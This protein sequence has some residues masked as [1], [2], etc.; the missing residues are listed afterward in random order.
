MMWSYSL[1]SGSATRQPLLVAE[2]AFSD[3]AHAIVS[4]MHVLCFH[5]QPCDRDNSFSRP[6]YTVHIGRALFDVFFNSHAGYRGAYFDSPGSGMDA[7]AEFMRI[8][9]PKLV[10]NDES[11][12]P[13][14]TPA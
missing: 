13:D 11:R 1:L 4:G 8:V 10:D 14:V 6:I 7:N 5:R 12:V 9:S 3:I 2:H